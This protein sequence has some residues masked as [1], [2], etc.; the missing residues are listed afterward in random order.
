[1]QV[2]QTLWEAKHK[3]FDGANLNSQATLNL[4]QPSDGV[5][6]NSQA[7]LVP[8]TALLLSLECHCAPLKL[9]AGVKMVFQHKPEITKERWV[10]SVSNFF[11]CKNKNK[12]TQTPNKKPQGGVMRCRETMGKRAGLALGCSLHGRDAPSCPWSNMGL[13]W[14]HRYLQAK[15]A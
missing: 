14:F 9:Q 6:F 11:A 5:S 12:N 4:Q 10:P 7:A 13:P 1:M 2:F 8:P 3:V 15:R